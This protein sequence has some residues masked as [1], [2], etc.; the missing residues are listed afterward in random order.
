VSS[1]DKKIK[2]NPAPKIEVPSKDKSTPGVDTSKGE[3]SEA[4]GGG[5][6]QI[7][8]AVPSCYTE[9]STLFDLKVE[10]ERGFRRYFC[11]N[12]GVLPSAANND[13][14]RR[15]SSTPFPTGKSPPAVSYA[16]R[17][18]ASSGEP[19]CFANGSRL[20]PPLDSFHALAQRVHED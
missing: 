14:W 13:S 17:Q 16:S 9:L 11:A 1:D 5:Q 4:E 7:A 10:T 8:E 12:V 15:C 3:G 2:T 19:Y 18:I 20:A 6:R